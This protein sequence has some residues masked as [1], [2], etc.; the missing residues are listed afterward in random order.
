MTGDAQGPLLRN[1]FHRRLRL[2]IAARNPHEEPARHARGDDA[3]REVER[4]RAGPRRIEHGAMGSAE[5]TTVVIMMPVPRFLEND[6]AP[7]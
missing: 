6:E 3:R 5:A 4:D 7:K 2:R 1:R